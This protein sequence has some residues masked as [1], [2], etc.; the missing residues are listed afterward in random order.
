MPTEKAQHAA[1]LSSHPA[2]RVGEREYLILGPLEVRR[3]GVPWTPNALKQRSLLTLL[4]LHANRS[5]PVGML[6]DELWDSR[7]PRTATATL[8][9][10]VSRLRRGLDP[11]HGRAGRDARGHPLLRTMGSGYLLSV[12]PGE[13]DLDR[14]RAMA[15]LGR[16]LM[17]AGECVLA[18]ESCRQALA[19]WRG[20]PLADLGEACLP[21][22]YAVRLEEERL[23]LVHSRIGADI[24]RGRALDVVGELEEL[25]ARHPLRE[26]FY[27]Q[28][29][30]AL[31]E[32]GRR[33]EALDAYA[34]ARRTV[35]ES[36]G[37]EPGPGLRSA[38]QALLTGARP[39]NAGHERCRPAGMLRSA[40]ARL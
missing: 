6:V 18:A 37:I 10:Y 23:A 38:Q 22:H 31:A 13:L 27:E 30:I 20:T 7:P 8:Q 2:Q 3:A 19:L 28:L 25:C 15:A 33:A 39:D 21:A 35:V 32:S 1:G 36:T 34:R 5:V 29:M 11:G 16:D 14:F 12:G 40:A 24:C 9:M 26:A 17:A 4:L